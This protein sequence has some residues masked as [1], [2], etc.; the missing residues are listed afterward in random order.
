IIGLI[1]RFDNGKKC[2]IT[3]SK[4]GLT[5]AINPDYGKENE[6][7]VPGRHNWVRCSAGLSCPI[8]GRRKWCMVSAEDIDNPPAVL[9]GM[10]EGSV[11]PC[12][13][14]TFLHILTPEGI[15]TSRCETVLPQTDLPVLIVEGATDVAAAADL[16]FVAVGRPSAQSGLKILREMPLHGRAIAV[17]GENDAGI[18]E[19][20]MESAY[21]TIGKLTTQIVRIMLPDGI[22]DLRAWVHSGLTKD[23]LLAQIDAAPTA[24]ACDVFDDDVAHTVAKSWMEEE[25]LESEFPIIRLYK[26]QWLR[27]AD[28]CYQK[29]AIEL[30]RGRLYQ[31]LDGKQYQKVDT[32]GVITIAP[33]KPSRAKVSDI[34]DALNQWC[35]ITKDPPLWLD[36]KKHPDPINLISFQNGVLNFNDYMNGKIVLTPSTPAFFNMNVIPY[37]FDETLE[38]KK[39]E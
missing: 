10:E 15:K 9:C 34:F 5:Y 24:P 39:W 36:D 26:G 37:A 19:I 31:F 8:C 11:G 17:I 30:L 7:Y 21:Q 1:R 14:G 4:R 12:G 23:L 29:E 16:G 32:N 38:S 22:K 33:Y 3:G 35:P 2:T 6:R 13:E 20:G 18:G 27:Y 25:L 28:G